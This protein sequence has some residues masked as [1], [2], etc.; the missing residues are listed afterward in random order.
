MNQSVG[1]VVCLIGHLFFQ[2]L[3]VK[4]EKQTRFRVVSR[5]TASALDPQIATSSLPTKIQTPLP[6]A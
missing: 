2:L 1:N 4:K 3:P 5:E 6:H